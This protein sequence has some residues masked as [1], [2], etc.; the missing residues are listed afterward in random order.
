MTQ[1][2]DEDS[3]PRSMQVEVE[4]NPVVNE[5]GA[6]GLLGVSQE[7]LKKWR[8]RGFG[9]NYIPYGENGPIRYEL[10]ELTEFREVHV[11]LVGPRN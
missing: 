7:L 4:E 9:P 3:G 11:V 10:N 2:S 1:P 8:Q 5:C 6:A